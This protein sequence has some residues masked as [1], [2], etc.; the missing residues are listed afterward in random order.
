MVV[1]Y[2]IILILFLELSL[3]NTA[4]AL[5]LNHAFDETN[6]TL[7]IKS[8]GTNETLITIQQV[9]AKPDLATMEEVFKITSYVNYT[10]NKSKDFNT[11]W[12]KFE[13]KN[14]ISNVKWEILETTGYNVT[15]PEFDLVEKNQTIPDIRSYNDVTEIYDANPWQ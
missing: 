8:P 7:I 3:I 1:K 14:K 6:R 12:K 13:G 4:S 5:N 9:S 15:M 2:K 11:N 10:F